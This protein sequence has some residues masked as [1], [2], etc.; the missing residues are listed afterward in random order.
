MVLGQAPLDPSTT[1]PWLAEGNQWFLALGD[2]GLEAWLVTFGYLAAALLCFWA[3]LRTLKEPSGQVSHAG[4]WLASGAVL[5]FMGL[6]KQLDFQLLMFFEVRR[7]AR[8]QGWYAYRHE[9][10]AACGAA[11]GLAAVVGFAVLVRLRAGLGRGSRVAV[12]GLF[13]LLVFALLRAAGITHI[14]A[15]LGGFAGRSHYTNLEA[16]G[17]AF[18]IAGAAWEIVEGKRRR[19][20]AGANHSVTE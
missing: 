2:S 12:F 13:V 1:A 3:A 8:E 18:A 14:G 5:L 6:N 9:F 19:T 17:V 4:M 20:V 11:A 16:L 10:V 15:A 7:M